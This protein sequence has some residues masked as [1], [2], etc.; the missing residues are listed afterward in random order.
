[1]FEKSEFVNEEFFSVHTNCI[2]F[3]H[4]YRNTKSTD[5]NII[6]KYI[7]FVESLYR[8]KNINF[9]KLETLDPVGIINIL[10]KIGLVLNIKFNYLKSN[11]VVMTSEVTTLGKIMEKISESNIHNIYKDG[12]LYTCGYHQESLFVH[13]H[14]AMLITLGYLPETLS[15]DRRLCIALA[16]L[17][18]D[19][20]KPGTKSVVETKYFFGDGNFRINKVTKFPCH[21]EIGSGIFLMAFTDETEKIIS[22]EEWEKIGRTICIHMCGYHETNMNNHQAKYTSSLL[23][24][25]DP[26]VKE[27]LLY[28]S[29]GDYLGGIRNSKIINNAKEFIDSRGNFIDEITKKFDQATF[30]KQ[31]NLNGLVILVRGMSGSG[32][33]TFTKDLSNHLENLKIPHII[34]ER[35][36]ILCEMAAKSIGQTLNK[37]ATGDDYNYLMKIYKEKKLATNV[38]SEMKQRINLALANN[39]VIILDTVMS[40][41]KSIDSVIPQSLSNSFVVAVDVIRNNLLIKEDAV[42]M[43]ISLDDQIK[44]HG[45][46]D[47]LYWLPD[48]TK[49]RLEELSSLSTS[50][51]N[52][53]HNI[54][55]P[56]LVHTTTWKLGKNEILKQITELSKLIWKHTR[57]DHNIFI[58][59]Y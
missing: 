59:E 48:D 52:K 8:L 19:I 42:R 44:F 43:G 3:F 9:M 10:R 29:Y 14:L 20:G 23:R 31:N 32:K 45:S 35:D 4:E 24:I 5:E 33:S 18:H 22:S 55:R 53:K 36:Q 2:D 47:I 6:E 27:N 39:K 28:L 50:K 25:E 11:G 12:K 7:K 16:A 40:L 21:G 49:M 54:L 46:R 30:F 57:N 41:F 56:R 26:I 15:E 13:L 17:L 38:N 1:M 37:R 58:S 34:I 51:I